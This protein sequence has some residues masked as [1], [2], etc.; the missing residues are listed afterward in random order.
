MSAPRV[1]RWKAGD[2]PQLL[3]AMRID[4]PD[5]VVID[6]S[7][8]PSQG[9][10]AA[11]FLRGQKATR[12][13][14]IVFLGG[15]PDK[16]EAIRKLL[17]DAVY[18]DSAGLPDAIRK[19]LAARPENPVVPMQMMA[20]YAA[21][22]TPQKLG[23]RENSTAALIDPPRNYE[24]MIG[25]LPA[26]AELLESPAAAAAVTLWFV[27]DAAGCRESPVADARVG[28]PHPALDP[29]AQRFGCHSAF[30]AKIRRRGRPRRLQNLLGKPRLERHALRPRAPA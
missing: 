15:A 9:R 18:A 7:R 17:P 25:E 20:R 28:R 27:H 13:I 5:A 21:R 8:L 3:R 16:V 26:G 14:P 29:L 4:P 30:P 6:L 11:I 19:A 22:T 12:Q 23:I 1:I 2:P 24:K 10:E